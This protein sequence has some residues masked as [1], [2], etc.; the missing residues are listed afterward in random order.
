MDFIHEEN[1]IYLIDPNNQTIAEVTFPDVQDNIV[2][3]DHTFVDPSLRGQGIAGKLM[4]ETVK[5]LRTKQKKAQLTCSYAV[6]WFKE[7]PE[8]KDVVVQDTL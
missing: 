7:H 5:H 4:E 2:N 3:I 1:R 8:C 6:S